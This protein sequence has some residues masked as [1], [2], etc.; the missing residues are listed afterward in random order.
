MST[1]ACR[2]AVATML[3]VS[4]ISCT[5]K[6]TLVFVVSPSVAATNAAFSTRAARNASGSS[7][8][9]TITR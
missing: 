2:L 3:T 9:P 8:S 1:D 6:A 7:S 5:V 4:L